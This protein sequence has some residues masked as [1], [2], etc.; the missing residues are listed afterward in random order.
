MDHTE[1]IVEIKNIVNPYFTKMLIS[2]MEDRCKEPLL[3][4]TGAVDKDIRNVLGY[5]LNFKNP[6][7]HFYWNYVKRQIQVHYPYYAVKFPRNQSRKM[8]QID[9]LKYTKGGKYTTHIDH[10]VTTP[11]TISVIV[12]LNEDYEGGDLVFTD[13]Q[14]KEVKRFKLKERSIIFFPSNFMYPHMIEPITKG[15][16]YSI[17]AWLQ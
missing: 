8:E 2:F 6:T 10:D 3:I 4:G 17:V 5:E 14:G 13:Q 12:N 15:T 11:R 16:R 7:N 9:L 1:A